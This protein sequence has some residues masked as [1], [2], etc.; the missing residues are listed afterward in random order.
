MDPSL[1]L[2]PGDD[3]A[4]ASDLKVYHIILFHF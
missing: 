2:G 3:G 1:E 4:L